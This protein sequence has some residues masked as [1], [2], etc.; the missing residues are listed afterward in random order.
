MT[1][2]R[3]SPNCLPGKCPWVLRVGVFF[4][5]TGNNKVND[6]PKNKVSNIAKLSELY[7]RQDDEKQLIKHH[8]IYKNGV[9]TVDYGENELAGL[10][11]GEGGIERVHEAINDVAKFFDETP[12]A[13]EFIVDVFGFSRGA[14]QARHFVNELHDRAAGPDVKVGFVGLFDTVASFALDY[15]GLAGYEDGSGVRD[16]AGDNINRYEVREYR[17]TRRQV[18]NPLD[19][20]E[21]E[22]PYYV[23]IIQPF[24][25]HL[26]GDSAD[27]IE[28]FV[29]RDEIRENFPLTS[30][31][32]RSGARIRE[33]SYV[34]VHSDIGGGYS[35][36]DDAIVENYIV[37]IK[38]LR[39]TY[40][41]LE[42]K[43]HLTTSELEQIKTEYEKLGYTLSEKQRGLDT[44]LYGTKNVRKE[45]SN[46]YLRY[47]YQKA[48]LTGVPF[49][50]LPSDVEHD[51]PDDL[52]DYAES[53][54]NSEPF[55]VDGEQDIYAKY[56]HQSYVEAEDRNS[57]LRVKAH[58]ADRANV[59]ESN[60]VRTVYPNEP[61]LAVIPEAND[62]PNEVGSQIDTDHLSSRNDS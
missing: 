3:H 10:S 1:K 50:S 18:V 43:E 20:M 28:Q 23:D 42:T 37:K 36:E 12:C 51:I 27:E 19:G 38:T 14:A 62:N 25:F 60:R 24:N 61:H 4:D 57:V 15:W 41:S 53:V 32:P 16:G 13:K 9:G 52:R 54:F 47:M 2:T 33:K 40:Y 29:A 6:F 30:L 31:E 46:V 39:R 44:W 26:S 7:E 59:P 45:L 11:L 55:P 49:T 21:I 34:G 17:G 56:V 8:M 35:N 5:G 58:F 22:A 48:L